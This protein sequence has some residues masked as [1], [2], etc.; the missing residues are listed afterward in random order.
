M[1]SACTFNQVLL[2]YPPPPPL[3]HFLSYLVTPSSL[4]YILPPPPPRQSLFHLLPPSN[5]FCSFSIVSFCCIL[6]F[7]PSFP[8]SSCPEYDQERRAGTWAM[9]LRPTTAISFESKGTN[10][11]AAERRQCFWRVNTHRVRA[12]STLRTIEW[13]GAF[14]RPSSIR[15]L[16]P[17]SAS[18]SEEAMLVSTKLAAGQQSFP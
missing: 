11:S 16:L 1:G 8:P 12:T 7:P 17:S 14:N 9:T 15:I 6:F 10:W 4:S 3:A 2:R 5:Q 13:T 18:R